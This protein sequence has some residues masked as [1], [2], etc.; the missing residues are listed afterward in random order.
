MSKFQRLLIVL[1]VVAVSFAFLWPT[2]SWYWLTPKADQALALG[3]REQIREYART[4]AITDLN[5]LKSSATAGD[6]SALNAQKFTVV[7]QAAS[8]AYGTAKKAAPSTWTSKA[9][10]AA[11][12]S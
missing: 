8:T 2:V 10:L 6:N 12:S 4:M 5:A 7:I 11:F 1:A 9:A 3:S